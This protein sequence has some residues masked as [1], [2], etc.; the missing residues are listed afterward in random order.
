MP[1]H[2]QLALALP[3]VG[4]GLQG[5]VDAQVLMVLGGQFDQ[6]AWDFLKQGESS[7]PGPTTAPVR[8]RR[9]A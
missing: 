9:A 7:P 5:V 2:A 3:D 1:E 6:P 4:Q 8:K